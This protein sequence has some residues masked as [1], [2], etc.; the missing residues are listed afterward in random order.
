[1]AIIEP[2]GQM[3][4]EVTTMGRMKTG[5]HE[6]PCLQ[7]TTSVLE[8]RITAINPLTWFASKCLCAVELK[9]IHYVPADSLHP[10]GV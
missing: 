6:S 1:M 10:N 4:N 2:D 3:A 8:S 9:G 5:G 7:L